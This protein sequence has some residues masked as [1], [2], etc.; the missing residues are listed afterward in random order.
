MN[1][2]RRQLEKK[3]IENASKWK[4]DNFSKTI[5]F[6]VQFLTFANFQSYFRYVSIK[7]LSCA[8]DETKLRVGRII[9]RRDGEEVRADRT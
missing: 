4:S 7:L 5:P 3:R 2:K 1:Y 8:D 9:L 6:K